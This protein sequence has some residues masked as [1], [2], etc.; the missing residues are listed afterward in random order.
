M[1]FD[2]KTTLSVYNRLIRLYEN[3]IREETIL[4]ASRDR[5][6][7]PAY[8]HLLRMKLEKVHKKKD[9]LLNGNKLERI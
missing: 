9:K 4:V 2:F 1:A 7:D 6:A 8:L 5:P 3:E